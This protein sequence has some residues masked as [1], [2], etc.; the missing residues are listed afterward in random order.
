M[1]L[2]QS[3]GYVATIGTKFCALNWEDQSVTVLATVEKDKKNNRFNDGKVDPSGRYFAGRV[4]LQHL[5]TELGE[6]LTASVVKVLYIID[7]G[8]FY[9]YLGNLYHFKKS[10]EKNFIDIPFSFCL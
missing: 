9:Y 7:P 10:L 4:Y 5:L 3:G 1:A 2:R 6:S 8:L